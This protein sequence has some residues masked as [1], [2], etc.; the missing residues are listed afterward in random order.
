[1][2][3]S[4]ENLH[5]LEATHNP[6]ACF[7]SAECLEKLGLNGNPFTAHAKDPFL[8][9]DQQIEMSINVLVDYLQNH[10]ATLV[11]AGEPGAGKTTHLRVLLR[12]GY[13]HF[14][15]CTFRAKPTTTFVEIEEK[16][17]QRWPLSEEQTGEELQNYEHIKRCVETGKQPVL[18]IDDAHRLSNHV[19]EALFRLKN[20]A[21]L[22][23]PAALGVVL[24]AESSMQLQLAELEKSIPAAT[25]VHQVNVRGFDVSR[26]ANYINHRLNKAGATTGELFSIDQ[27]QEFHAASQG[28]PQ[29]INQLVCEALT[30]KC[31]QEPSLKTPINQFVSTY[32]KRAGVL[33]A[34]LIGLAVIISIYMQKPGKDLEHESEPPIPT[35]SAASKPE[36]LTATTD[37]PAHAVK[38]SLQLE[39]PIPT[40]SAASKPETLTATTDDP[41]HAVKES[42]QLEP[43][44]PTDSAASKPE[45]L[46]ATTDD[47]AHAVKESLQLEPPI[48]TDSAAS[49]PETLTATTDDP[50]HAVKESLP[51]DATLPVKQSLPPAK[52]SPPPSIPKA[53]KPPTVTPKVTPKATPKSIAAQPLPQSWLLKQSAR[54]YTLQILASSS[55]QNV[56][57]FAKRNASI[58]P[59]AY[60]KKT[61]QNKQ[62]FVLV[63][64]VFST[65][66]QALAAVKSLP[67]N[68]TK[69]KP[70]PVKIS[71]IQQIIR[72]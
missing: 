50:A 64:G 30:K 26:C 14:N 1:M 2:Q 36:T 31:Q 32:G 27:I 23:S 58:K 63:H 16:I 67:K 8:F 19:L 66:E 53:V 49:K 34:G 57:A 42:L 24:V 70:Y 38:E 52:T 60:Y 3:E 48:P 61:V 68:I 65:R 54:A 11:I 18:V 35:D 25:Q 12:K 39:P 56:L 71:E 41:A 47:P 46:T 43:P 44:I 20:L 9:V 6:D 37:D 15:F 17:R 7:I 21:G 13:Q 4:S 62:W 10:N 29:V 45:T 69:N 55:K 33:L 72:Q 40:D 22:Q 51:Q 5:N 28:L 59:T